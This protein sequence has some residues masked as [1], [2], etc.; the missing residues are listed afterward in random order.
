MSRQVHILPAVLSAAI[1][2]FGFGYVAVG[3][4]EVTDAP[5]R[6]DGAPLAGELARTDEIA[7][8]YVRAPRVRLPL[9]V[10]SQS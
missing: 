8:V 2:L 1:V 4:G 10:S 6:I 3:R 9:S 5:A 7:T